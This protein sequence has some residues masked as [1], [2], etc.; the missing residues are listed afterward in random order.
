MKERTDKKIINE[1]KPLSNVDYPGKEQHSQ[2][3]LVVY[4]SQ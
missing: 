2:N 1:C 3:V 4:A